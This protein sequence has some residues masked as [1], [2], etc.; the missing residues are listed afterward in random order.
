MFEV[1]LKEVS[2]GETQR[3]IMKVDKLE[4]ELKEL[5]MLV[6]QQKPQNFKKIVPQLDMTTVSIAKATV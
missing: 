4:G 2:I 6:E 1:K 5:R 3:L